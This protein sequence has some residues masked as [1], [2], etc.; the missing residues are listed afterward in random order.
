MIPLAAEDILLDWLHEKFKSNSN[1]CE[2]WIQWHKMLQRIYSN[3]DDKMNSGEEN[4]RDS[5]DNNLVDVY[6][7]EA[8]EYN[9][10]DEAI[11]THYKCYQKLLNSLKE[12]GGHKEKEKNIQAEFPSLKPFFDFDSNTF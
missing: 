6:I 1:E 7:F 12:S 4:G 10:F 5:D 8:D 9:T 2:T 11:Y 3:D